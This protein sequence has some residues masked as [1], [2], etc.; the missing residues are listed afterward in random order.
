MEYSKELINLELKSSCELCGST[1]KLEH[2]RSGSQKLG[3]RNYTVC[4]KCSDK[5]VMSDWEYFDKRMKALNKHVIEYLK[6][7]E[8]K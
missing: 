2:M 6:N 7:K 5:A 3:W 1:N 4:A 8:K